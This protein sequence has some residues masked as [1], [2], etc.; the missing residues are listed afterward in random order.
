MN[1]DQLEAETAE[2]LPGREALGKFSFNFAKMT[3]VT[4]KV[5]HV[6]AHNESAALNQCSPYAVAQSEAAQSIS[7]Q[8]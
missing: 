1:M 8:Q 6:D 4:K 7:V 5:A 3:T 2:L